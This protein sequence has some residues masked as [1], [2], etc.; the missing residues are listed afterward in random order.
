LQALYQLREFLAVLTATHQGRLIAAM[1][2]HVE[3][4]EAIEETVARKQ[5]SSG[6]R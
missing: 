6:P 1:P 5:H 4:L 2:G 3:L